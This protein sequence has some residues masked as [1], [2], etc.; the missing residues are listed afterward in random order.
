MRR[1][2]QLGA[3]LDRVRRIPDWRP[4]LEPRKVWITGSGD[5]AALLGVAVAGL[6][7]EHVIFH[8][9]PEHPALP[10]LV[11]EKL[12]R[13]LDDVRWER[14]IR[15][16]PRKALNL[17]VQSLGLDLFIDA[18]GRDRETVEAAL[19]ADIPAYSAIARNGTI[20]FQ[21][22]T[23]TPSEARLGPLPEAGPAAMEAC[24]ALAGFVSHDYALR[25]VLEQPD[26]ALPRRHFQL[27]LCNPWNVN[28]RPSGDP[29]GPIS[30]PLRV[31]LVGA[32]GLGCPGAL[33]L[34][35]RLPKGSSVVVVDPDRID[36][37][38]RSR[39]FTFSERDAAG[40]LPKATT[41]CRELR[42]LRPHIEWIPVPERFPHPKALENG[43]FDVA[44][45]FTDTFVSR[46]AVDRYAA[47]PVVLNAAVDEASAS[48]ALFHGETIHLT[49]ALRLR[50]LAVRELGH[51]S[52]SSADPSIIS[53]N[54]IA[55]ALAVGRLYHHVASGPEPARLLSYELSNDNRGGAWPPFPIPTPQRN[56]QPRA[57]AR[58]PR[59]PQ[60]RRG[61]RPRRGRR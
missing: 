8:Q 51:A 18:T 52:C 34:A 16:Y 1:A 58:S 33:C 26:R 32:G 39:Q 37:T 29:L 50:E 45:S 57:G 47:A 40:T 3:V 14:R 54:F 12:E 6:G 4:D 13:W 17:V 23:P 56:M 31:L 43:P 48:A 30:K 2:R 25:H 28:E 22:A 49:D 46:V 20:A 7:A 53:T 19:A 15:S 10:S 27:D 60:P 41:L 9:P 61:P 38:N 55:A 59:G 44:C 21:A 36:P 11:E 35:T 42:E 24:V 5:Q